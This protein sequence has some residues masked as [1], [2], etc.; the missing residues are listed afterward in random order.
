MTDQTPQ[1]QVE[2][3]TKAFEQDFGRFASL[4]EIHLRSALGLDAAIGEQ[5]AVA[6]L[7]TRWRKKSELAAAEVNRTSC[8]EERAGFGQLV[9]ATQDKLETMLEIRSG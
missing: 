7:R 8:P 5:R 3:I 2:S 6:D 1:A 9:Q 4:V